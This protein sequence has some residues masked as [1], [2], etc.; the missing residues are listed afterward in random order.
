MQQLLSPC[1]LSQIIPLFLYFIVVFIFGAASLRCAPPPTVSGRKETGLCTSE[2]D[3]AIIS[4]GNLSLDFLFFSERPPMEGVM[5]EPRCC[6]MAPP[7]PT[8]VSPSICCGS[9]AA[10]VAKKLS[11]ARNGSTSLPTSGQS[12]CSGGFLSPLHACLSLNT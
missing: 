8:A 5:D 9:D 6:W 1:T 7:P 11:V 2:R 3:L 12:T 10:E 4:T